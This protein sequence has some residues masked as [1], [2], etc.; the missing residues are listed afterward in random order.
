[1]PGNLNRIRI[2]AIAVLLVSAFAADK[3]A[4][5]SYHAFLLLHSAYEAGAPEA[6]SVRSWMTLDYVAATYHVPRSV[7]TQRLG[8]PAAT[9]PHTRLQVLADRA[10]LSRA[11]YVER[12]QRVIGAAAPRAAAGRPGPRRQWFARLGDAVLGAVLVHGYAALGLALLLASLGVPVPDAL[13]TTIAGSLVAQH[14]LH[15]LWAGTTAVLAATLGDI[16]GYALGWFVGRE[17]FER[18][19]LWFRRPVSRHG[20]AVRMFERSGLLAVFASHTLLSTGSAAINMLAGMNR[21]RP[22]AFL[23]TCVAGRVLWTAACMSLGYAI[24]PDP[25]A[26]SGFLTDLAILFGAVTGVVAAALVAT[27][28]VVLAPAGDKL[29]RR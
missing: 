9:D 19:R 29:R 12:V 25:D 7:L 21:L 23:A 8:L 16:V 6:S 18:S 5:R 2:V 24:G 1:M 17:L 11:V 28:R 22:S 26:A 10:G 27:G 14:R 15:W 20:P 4:V 13:A 3:F